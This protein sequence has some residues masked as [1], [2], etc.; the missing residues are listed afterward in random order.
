M[1][2]RAMTAYIMRA[3]RLA[4]SGGGLEPRAALDAVVGVA[5]W[6]VGEVSDQEHRKRWEEYVLQT[7][8]RA[9]S[10]VSHK[11]QHGSAVQ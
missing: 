9:V 11:R 1:D 10:C 4:V 6:M 7:F 3:V 2:E 8:P 5:A